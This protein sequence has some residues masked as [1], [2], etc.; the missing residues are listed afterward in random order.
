MKIIVTSDAHYGLKS[1]DFDRTQEIHEVITSIIDRCEEAD[2]FVHCGDLG[3]IVNPHSKIHA[4]WVKLF[5]ELRIHGVPSYF[6]LG[7]HDV[8][9][10]DR[11]QYG[12]LAPLYE[13]ELSKIEPI[14]E[15]SIRSVITGR[16]SMAFVF[17]PYGKLSPEDLEGYVD[18][19]KEEI[20]ILGVERLIVFTHLNVDGAEVSD[21]FILRPVR[22]TVPQSLFGIPEV[23]LVVSGHI[24]KHQVVRKEHPQ[25]VI[26]GSPVHSNFGDL[27]EKVYLGINVE[28]DSITW[29]AIPT[30]AVKLIELDYDFTDCD[31][32]LSFDT[33]SI[34]DAGVKVN[35]RCREDQVKE[36][37]L[38]SFKE[39][40]EAFAQF[41]RPI[42]PTVVRLKDERKEVINSDM[43]NGE[44]INAFLDSRKPVNK[45]LIL[46]CAMEAMEG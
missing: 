6:L 9:A 30:G 28:D 8:S 13:L 31:I 1:K 12:S 43:S 4:L 27:S 41:V 35:I 20:E 5:E 37:Q 38:D 21:D 22:S 25:H 19:L 34:T 40:L 44:V 23:K 45:K 10:R 42:T 32:D 17:F 3:H 7:N 29:K 15:F 18:G 2:V 46:E 36:L 11:N 14:C 33:D 16:N 26:V 39:D 24:H